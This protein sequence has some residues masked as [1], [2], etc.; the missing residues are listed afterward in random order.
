MIR[1]LPEQGSATRLVLVRHAETEVSA[2]GRCYGSLDVELSPAGRRQAVGLGEALRAL[3]LAAVY[4]SPLRRALDTAT[5]VASAQGLEPL[6]H[7][8]LREL[9]FGE[10]EGLT[11]ESI[12]AE[13]PELYRSWMERPAA[14]RFPGGESFADLRSRVLATVA[15]IRERHEG[16]TVAMVAHGGVARVV[17][18]EALGLADDSLFRLDQSCGGVSIVDWVEGTPVVRLVNAVLYSAA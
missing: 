7:N 17:L 5:A 18:A 12:E 1:S 9:D 8:G 3:P 4:T 14:V 2:R 10:L 11:Y 16:E 13:R 6:P 15:G